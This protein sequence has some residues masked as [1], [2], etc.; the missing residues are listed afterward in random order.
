MDVTSKEAI[1]NKTT[2]CYYCKKKCKEGEFVRH[3]LKGRGDLLHICK[4]CYDMIIS[5]PKENKNGES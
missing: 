1:F 4:E 3:S 5:S 2:N